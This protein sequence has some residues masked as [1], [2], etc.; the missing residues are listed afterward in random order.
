M[1][2]LSAFGLRNLMNRFHAGRAAYLLIAL[3]LIFTMKRQPLELTVNGGEPSLYENAYFAAAMNLPFEGGGFRFCPE[4]LPDDDYLDL[5]IA[6]DI[7]LIL[8][9]LLL[10]RLALIRLALISFLLTEFAAG[11][12]PVVRLRDI[13]GLLSRLLGL[14]FLLLHISNVV[15]CSRQSLIPS[16]QKGD[17]SKRRHRPVF[18]PVFLILQQPHRGLPT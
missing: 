5:I 18:V 13:F 10:I 15:L 7:S 16:I 2:P 3:K 11:R 12:I 4:A 9:G 6:H 14:S 17:A 8:T 1:T